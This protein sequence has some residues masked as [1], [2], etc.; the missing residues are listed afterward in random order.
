[1]TRDG[2]VISDV[3]GSHSNIPSE[4]LLQRR[5]DG[6]TK[7]KMLI[8]IASESRPTMIAMDLEDANTESNR[9]KKRRK[10]VA[11]FKYRVTRNA[12]DALG[13]RPLQDIREF[14][15]NRLV[16]TQDQFDKT[17]LDEILIF[18]LHLTTFI[19]DGGKE[20]KSERVLYSSKTLLQNVKRQL[21]GVKKNEISLTS[22][23][24]FSLIDNNWALMSFGTTSLYRKNAE[25]V[26]S[27]YRPFM[28]LVTRTERGDGYALIFTTLLENVLLWLGISKET[29]KVK[30]LG[31]DHH[32]GLMKAEIDRAFVLTTYCT[33]CSNKK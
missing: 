17:N 26:C 2:R 9:F 23:T 3:S 21:D 12:T 24:T 18:G 19:D 33:Y 11:N 27:T 29:Y 32:A 30:M 28:F 15:G 5:I 6:E 20:V 4:K 7:G 25:T 22:D 10:Q 13:M 16:T 31:M 14:I 1:L 8:S